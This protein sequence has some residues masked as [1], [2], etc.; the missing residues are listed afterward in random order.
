MIKNIY[1]HS[2]FIIFLIYYFISTEILQYFIKNNY[3]LDY[4]GKENFIFFTKN[5]S[6]YY[7]YYN[8]FS[9]I[10]LIIIYKAFQNIFEIKDQKIKNNN[11]N[12]VSLSFN[13]VICVCLLFLL[14]DIYFI[15]KYISAS[16]LENFYNRDLL[17]SLINNRKTHLNILII[18]SVANFN[19]NPRLS[20][21][22][23]FLILIYDLITLSRVDIFILLIL[24]YFTNVNLY[25][26]NKK[27]IY[28]LLFFITFIFLIIFYRY[29]FLQQNFVKSFFSDAYFLKIS[30][31]IFFSNILDINFYK[32]ILN[33]IYFLLNDFFY[34]NFKI[35]N[36][37]TLPV[38][39][40][41]ISIRGIDAITCYFLVFLIYYYFIYFLIKN[42][43]LNNNLIVSIHLFILIALFRGNSVHTLGFIIKL[44]LLIIFLQWFIKNLQSLKF[45]AD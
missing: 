24:H 4:V 10:F 38:G 33:N 9:I 8:I 21:L 14:K 32:Y 11:Y 20:Y 2:L 42:W 12:H 30:S 15:I 45:K 41:V 16:P 37:F 19:S 13:I 17:Y 6:V 23:Y 26:L 43:P 40:L 7:N 39:G 5:S 36:F 22:S 25:K 3:V 31:Q 28:L 18:L 34:I 44:Y 29:Y 27:N 35:L 1:K